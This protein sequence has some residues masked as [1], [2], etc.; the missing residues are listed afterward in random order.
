MLPAGIIP[1][2]TRRSFS[3]R[4]FVQRVDGKLQCGPLISPGAIVR[5]DRRSR[6]LWHIMVVDR[7]TSSSKH[8]AWL[9]CRVAGTL[10]ALPLDG[11]QAA[12]G[13]DAL[14]VNPEDDAQGVGRLAADP[15]I[16]IESLRRRLIPTSRGPAVVAPQARVLVWS[17]GGHSAG[18]L[19]DEVVRLTTTNLVPL[20]LSSIIPQITAGAVTH[21][22]RW[23]VAAR[24][25]HLLALEPL[26][27]ASINPAPT[28]NAP[29][30]NSPTF[31]APSS[32]R[33]ESTCEHRSVGTPWDAPSAASEAAARTSQRGQ[34]L[35]VAPPNGEAS[36]TRWVFSVTQVLGAAATAAVLPIPCRHAHFPGVV[37]HENDVVPLWHLGAMGDERRLI[38]VRSLSGRK[39]AIAAAN[40]VRTFTLPQP[41]EPIDDESAA[42]T[43]LAATVPALAKY[44]S[45]NSAMWVLP[46]LDALCEFP[47]GDP[48]THVADDRQSSRATERSVSRPIGSNVSAA[49]SPP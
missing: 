45:S 41:A 37:V 31:N 33:H 20:E 42:P 24:P 11:L 43:D 28:F 49:G 23:N 46:D 48:R 15:S 47:A 40:D 36:A 17:R 30:F 44:R 5:E 32:V 1:L 3:T 14:A 21:A 9:G 19:V 25:V 7:S 8:Q 4:R 34:I 16:S 27:L 29:T 26:R 35:V 12:Y 6:P 18:W 22:Y 2:G 38:V 10:Y 13:G 39:L